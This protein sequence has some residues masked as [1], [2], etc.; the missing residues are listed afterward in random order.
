MRSLPCVL[1]LLLV[2]CD[3]GTT[4]DSSRTRDPRADGAMPPTGPSGLD[5]DTLVRGIV[6]YNSCNGDDG[7]Y[8]ILTGIRAKQG[9]YPYPPFPWACMASVTNGCPGVLECF[10]LAA[11]RPGDVSGTCDGAVAVESAYRWDCRKVGGSCDNGRC[12]W[13]GTSACDTSMLPPACDAE[14]RPVDCDSRLVSRGPS[15]SALGLACKTDAFS[16]YCEGTGAACTAKDS[17]YFAVEP[18]GVACD[19]GKLSACVHGSM[20]TLDCAALGDGFT[21]QA[22]NGAF[23][24]G[25]ASE[26]DPAADGVHCDGSSAVICDAGKKRTVDC[27]ALGFKGCTGTRSIVCS[28]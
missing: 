26:C 21:C 3:G 15:C 7:P 13:P 24:C 19:G 10:G 17:G 16:A 11:L 20:A 18:I 9:G 27:V 14:G 4:V 28:S 2:T 25:L 22:A 12:A 1:A 5:A 8:R 6:A 23:F